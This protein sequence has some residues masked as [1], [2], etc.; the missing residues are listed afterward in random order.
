MQEIT[1]PG[2]EGA[3]A[4]S[5]V[6]DEPEERVRYSQHGVTHLVLPS[7]GTIKKPTSLTEPQLLIWCT[8]AMETSDLF[9]PLAEWLVEERWE[10]G[11][12]F[13][14]DFGDF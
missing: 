5:Y 12:A 1:V 6:T 14:L 7:A 11:N 9:T 4:S 2:G 10:K 13:N 3:S 8:V